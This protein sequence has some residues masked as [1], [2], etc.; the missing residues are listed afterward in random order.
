M[1]RTLKVTKII[2]SEVISSAKFLN[3]ICALYDR[4]TP[5]ASGQC[6]HR[7]PFR[8]HHLND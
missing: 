6:C 4:L 7:P 5:P 8:P 1:V 2:Q 3:Q